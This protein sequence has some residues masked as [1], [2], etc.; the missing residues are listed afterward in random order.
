MKRFLLSALIVAFFGMML[1]AQK[2]PAVYPKTADGDSLM[3]VYLNS[4]ITAGKAVL[5]AGK[6]GS[7]RGMTVLNGKMYITNRTGGGSL[8][9]HLIELNGENGQLLNDYELPDDVFKA[10]GDTVSYPGNDVQRDEAGN[11][12][13]SNMTLDMRSDANTVNRRF[14]ISY[15]DVTKSPIEFKVILDA[16]IPETVAAA[17]RVETFDVYGDVKNGDGLIMMP[18][19]GNEV[20]AGNFV[21]KY[22]VT[23]GVVDATKPEFIEIK[24]YYPASATTNSYAPRINIVDKTLFYADGFSNNPS[25]YDM[26]GNMVDGFKN[27]PDLAPLGAGQNGVT[28]FEMNGKY[29]LIVASTNTDKAPPQAFDIFQFKDANRAFADM[30]LLYRF[31]EAGMGAVSNPVRTALPRVEIQGA[32]PKQYARINLY[33]FKNGYGVYHFG[34]SSVINSMQETVANELRISVTGNL[35]KLSKDA[36]EI[37]IYNLAGQKIYQASNTE[38]AVIPAKGVYIIKAKFADKSEKAFK[39]IVK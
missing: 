25:L 24:E 5:P 22:T 26:S 7:A 34:P 11:L 32:S 19:S 33:A 3:S 13:V 31:P 27:N 6:S 21:I 30:K 38:I 23:G 20:G 39:V 35:V 4:A 18:I 12:F 1:H 2:D 14:R 16:T 9:V 37:K 28:E 10:D 17:C 15:V 29:Y 36:K 8:P